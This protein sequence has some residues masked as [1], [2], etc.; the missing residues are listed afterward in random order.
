VHRPGQTLNSILFGTTQRAHSLPDQ[1]SVNISG[2]SIPLSNQVKILGAV[3]DS[4]I[5]LS[6]HTT[7]VSKSCFYHI[8]ALKQIRG[9]LDDLTTQLSA[10]LPLLLFP[11]DSIMITPFY[12]AFQLNTSLVS[13]AHKIP[14]HV[15]S[16]VL[17]LLS[18]AHSL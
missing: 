8:R 10:L 1:I 7:A 12:M 6:Q 18:P 11:P 4:R 2:V 3:L 16:Q 17:A 5:T 14:L 15:L 9:S 13:S